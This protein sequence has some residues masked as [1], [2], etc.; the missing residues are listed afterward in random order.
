[1]K[2]NKIVIFKNKKFIIALLK[3]NNKYLIILVYNQIL[4]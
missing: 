4:Y 3:N 2:K 1:M